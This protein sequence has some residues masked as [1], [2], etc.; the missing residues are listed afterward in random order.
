MKSHC[1]EDVFIAIEVS[2]NLKI[3]VFEATSDP[4]VQLYVCEGLSPKSRGFLIIFGAKIHNN[5]FSNSFQYFIVNYHN[6]IF[7]L[8]HIFISF[9]NI[10]H[11]LWSKNRE[12]GYYASFGEFTE[13]EHNYQLSYFVTKNMQDFTK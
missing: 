2:S 6:G 10:L 13:K 3:D 5:Q 11:I 12:V 9:G 4:W 8:I 7:L 1:F